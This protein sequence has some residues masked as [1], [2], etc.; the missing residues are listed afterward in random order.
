MNAPFGKLTIFETDESITVSF[1][2]RV[3]TI[4]SREPFYNI[5]KKCLEIDDMVPF[6]IEIARREGKGQ[7]FRDRLLEEIERLEER[8]E[9]DWE[10]E[11]D[12]NEED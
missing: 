1:E 6:Y 5:A 3:Y 11:D 12:W 2:G 7:A 8:E 4:S 9:A 10:A